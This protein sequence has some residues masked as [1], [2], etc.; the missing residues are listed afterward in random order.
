M[1]LAVGADLVSKWL[2]FRYVARQPVVIDYYAV[3]AMSAEDPRRI[4]EIIQHQVGI[5]EPVHVLPRLLDLTLVLNPGAVFGIGPGQ[6][7]FFI[8]FTGLALGFGVWMFGRWTRPRDHWA[9]AAIGLL[10]GGGLGNLYDRLALG[11]VRDFLHPLPELRFPFG[12]KPL[13]N[14][15]EIWPYVSNIADL[16]L[17][18]GI[19]ML[20]FTMSRREPRKHARPAPAPAG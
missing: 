12:W 16:L 14:N 5:P 4:G 6:R 13:G 9:H 19:G 10:L 2:A 18:I 3:M 17:L 1:V 20:L 7:W 15:G 8:V 11:C